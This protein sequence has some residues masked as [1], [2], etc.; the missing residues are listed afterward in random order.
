MEILWLSASA[1]CYPM[2]LALPLSQ[3]ACKYAFRMLNAINFNLQQIA[4]SSSLPLPL[5]LQ[6]VDAIAG[7][8]LINLR[9][10]RFLVWLCGTLLTCSRKVY[11]TSSSAGSWPALENGKKCS[12]RTR[13][14]PSLTQHF[15]IVFMWTGLSVRSIFWSI[16][17]VNPKGSAQLAEAC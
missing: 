13:P 9:S 5:P 11:W 14:R 16:A 4:S 6:I 15:R 3:R 8:S 12:W 2:P 7:D 1:L 10:F 17:F